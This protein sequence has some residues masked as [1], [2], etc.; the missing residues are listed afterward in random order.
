MT[1]THPPCADLR[2]HGDVAM[3]IAP[4]PGPSSDTGILPALVQTLVLFCVPEHI[5][6]SWSYPSHMARLYA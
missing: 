2:T 1:T 4:P 6:K 3:Y 5:E